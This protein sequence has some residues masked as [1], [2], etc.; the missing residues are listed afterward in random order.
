[1]FGGI[2]VT[3]FNILRRVD[4]EDN[5]N[6]VVVSV[7]LGLSLLVIA[8]P[9]FFDGFPDGVKIVVGNSITLA[10]VSAI[11]LN[12]L[13]NIVGQRARGAPGAE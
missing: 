9:L 12:W 6:L 8:N 13:F 4:L 5:R 1:M 10:G 11:V 2:A 3:G 7:S